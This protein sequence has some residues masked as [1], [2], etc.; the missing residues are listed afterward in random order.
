MHTQSF[1]EF[2]KSH[3]LNEEEEG[4]MYLQNLQEIATFA[5]E[6]R[7]LIDP[8]DDLEAWVQDKITVAH[9]NMDAILGYYNSQKKETTQG[10]GAQSTAGL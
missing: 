8:K 7:E 1:T 2:N 4:K 9:H 3:R 5:Q 6:I 10:A